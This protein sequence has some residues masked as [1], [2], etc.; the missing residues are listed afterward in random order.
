M[1]E[2]EIYGNEFSYI[3]HSDSTITLFLHICSLLFFLAE[4]FENKLQ[5]SWHFISTYYI[6]YF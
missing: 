6:M 2:V 3:H 4:I 1:L 5:T